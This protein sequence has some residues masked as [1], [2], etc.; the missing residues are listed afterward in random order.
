MGGGL[1]CWAKEIKKQSSIAKVLNEKVSP[2]TEWPGG[3]F[4][5]GARL[6]AVNK[7]PF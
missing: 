7:F 2:I 6:D 3:I 1:Y 5:V 4:G